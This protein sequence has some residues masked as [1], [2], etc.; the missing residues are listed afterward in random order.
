M[1]IINT[2]F[3]GLKIIKQKNNIDNRGSLRE[4]YNKKI[5]YFNNFCFLPRSSSSSYLVKD[6][7]LSLY[8]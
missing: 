7:I 2:K 8:L 3:P 5:I 4:T 6:Q 1:K